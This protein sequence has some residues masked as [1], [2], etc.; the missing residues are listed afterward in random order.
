M[1][2]FEY[3]VYVRVKVSVGFFFLLSLNNVR[4]N[5]KSSETTK[6]DRIDFPLNWISDLRLTI[7]EI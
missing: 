2:Y 3:Y 6:A 5:R 4:V 1:S 7:G